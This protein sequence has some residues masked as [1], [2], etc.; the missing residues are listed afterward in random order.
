MPVEYESEELVHHG[1]QLVW[2][3]AFIRRSGQATIEGFLHGGGQLLDGVDA[4]EPSVPAAGE[5]LPRSARAVGRDDGCAAR[6]RFDEHR[7]ETFPA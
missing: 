1:V 2:A 3:P 7:R 5:D 4:D 6:Q